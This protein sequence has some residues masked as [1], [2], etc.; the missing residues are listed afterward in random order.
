MARGYRHGGM[1]AYSEVQPRMKKL[2]WDGVVDGVSWLFTWKKSDS[3]SSE[4]HSI[5]ET[6]NI[7]C[8]GYYADCQWYTGQIDLTEYDKIYFTVTEGNSQTEGGRKV[9]V[10]IDSAI[11]T[12]YSP[13]T[14]GVSNGTYALN[15]SS[16]KGFYYIGVYCSS[17][18]RW[19]YGPKI[20]VSR[21]WLEKES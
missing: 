20:K 17:Q 21:V 10:V 6:L 1:D 9:G 2:F 5:T 14:T 7:N 8:S 3:D 15:I 4:S 19:A 12:G 16:L 11:N 13:Q 18:N